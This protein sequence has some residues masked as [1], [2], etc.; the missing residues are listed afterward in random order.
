MRK[1]SLVAALL[2]AAGTLACANGGHTTSS[3]GGSDATQDAPGKPM[4]TKMPG[5]GQPARDGK[6]EFVV[7]KMDCSKTEVGNQFLNAK[8]Q[9]KFCL[10]TLTVRNIGIEA[11]TFDASSQHALDAKNTVYDTDSGA[12]V[13]VNEHNET[14]L[15]S[16]NPGNQVKGVIPFDVPKDVTITVLEL[17]D[18][19]FS[20]GVDIKVG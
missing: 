8:A 5:I 10:V 12:A 4:S 3:S 7:S 16:I 20:E 6:F 1:I 13:Y 9:G 17:H 14:F 18:S 11:Q 15:N 19:P 2:L